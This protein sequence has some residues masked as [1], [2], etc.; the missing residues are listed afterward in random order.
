MGTSS[1]LAMSLIGL[2]LALVLGG[3][4]MSRLFGSTPVAEPKPPSSPNSTPEHQAERVVDAASK[5]DRQRLD[6][7]MKALDPEAKP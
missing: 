5:A 2:L 6:N 7:A 3:V 1:A 4:L